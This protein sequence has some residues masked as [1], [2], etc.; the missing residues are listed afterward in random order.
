MALVVS[1]ALELL[2]LSNLMEVAWSRRMHANDQ[3]K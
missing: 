3:T 1:N 2:G